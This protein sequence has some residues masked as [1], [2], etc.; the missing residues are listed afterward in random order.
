[1]FHFHQK[2]SYTRASS[3]FSKDYS[4][5]LLHS[6]S[7]L[8]KELKLFVQACG[9]IHAG[10]ESVD[11]EF[12]YYLTVQCTTFYLMRRKRNVPEYLA[13]RSWKQSAI[14][15]MSKLFRVPLGVRRRGYNKLSRDNNNVAETSQQ[16]THQEGST[17]WLEASETTGGASEDKGRRLSNECTASSSYLS[18]P[19]SEMDEDSDDHSWG[20]LSII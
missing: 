8:T 4:I 7:Q 6:T 19:I 5:Q 13:L 12:F 20:N 3:L 16:H 10:K 11:Q 14:A 15:I 9:F 18:S 1:M 17:S 2:S